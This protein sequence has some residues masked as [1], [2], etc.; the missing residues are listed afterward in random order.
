MEKRSNADAVTGPHQYLYKRTCR[1]LEYP[2]IRS[3]AASLENRLGWTSLT[4][5]CKLRRTA[6]YRIN[7]PPPPP[8]PQRERERE[9]SQKR[10][11]PRRSQVIQPT[12]DQNTMPIT[13]DQ[14]NITTRSIIPPLLSE[15]KVSRQSISP[16][17]RNRRKRKTGKI[18]PILPLGQQTTSRPEWMNLS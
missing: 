15:S 14:K 7:L 9:S 16:K 8:P 10:P 3:L 5:V 11:C 18:S 6:H 17:A 13:F 2:T 1:L 12:A 4:T